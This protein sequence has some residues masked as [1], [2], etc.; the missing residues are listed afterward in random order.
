MN[1]M[2]S[3][4]FVRIQRARATL[5]L[6]ARLIAPTQASEFVERGA[7]RSEFDH[8]EPETPLFDVL[9]VS[10]ATVGEMDQKLGKWREDTQ[11]SKLI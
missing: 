7:P 11:S 1:L 3:S 10:Q 8:I 4:L 5:L 9:L 2:L 6:I